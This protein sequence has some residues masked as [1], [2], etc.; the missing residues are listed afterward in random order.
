M[1]KLYTEAELKK[2]KLS[3]LRKLAEE[4]DIDTEGEP[5]ASLIESLLSI[6]APEADDE[7]E[8]DDEEDDEVDDEAEDEADDEEE[9]DLELDEEEVDELPAE[10]ARKGRMK[11]AEGHMRD[12]DKP[13]KKERKARA[14]RPVKVDP[15]G[16]PTLAAKQVAL[17]LKTEP[18]T[19]RQFFR[20]DASTLEAVGSGGRYE[21]LESDLPTIKSEFEAW[22]AAHASRGSK[23]GPRAKGEDKA[24]ADV[25]EEVEEIEEL[26]DEVEL[27]DDEI[28]DDDLELD[29]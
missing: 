23:R 29:E 4:N 21:F 7:E 10:T 9:D 24:P 12:N 14:D 5:K 20:S 26:D 27:D 1:A 17:I 19:L 15:D 22:Q 25:V 16:K 13:A 6:E 2:L 8:L 28:D 18:K 11:E 3:E